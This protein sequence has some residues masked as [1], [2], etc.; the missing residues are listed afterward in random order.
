M[1]WTALFYPVSSKEKFQK[2]T[3]NQKSLELNQ[4]SLEIK[5]KE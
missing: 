3:R 1:F 2:F 5:L 4:K